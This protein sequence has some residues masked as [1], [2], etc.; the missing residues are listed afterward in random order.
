M[1]AQETTVDVRLTHDLAK[2][3]GISDSSLRRWCRILEFQGYQFVLGED[4]ARVF[5]ERDMAALQRFQILV[6]H[7]RMNLED[8]AKEVMDAEAGR[9]EDEPAAFEAQLTALQPAG[10][11]PV[12]QADLIAHLK[13]TI[14]T[15]VRMGLLPE[16]LT[17]KQ[18][19]NEMDFELQELKVR[20]KKMQQQFAEQQQEL[21][22]LKG[23]IENRVEQRDKELM[24]AL[25]EIQQTKTQIAASR[26]RRWWKF[27]TWSE[28]QRG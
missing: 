6:K 14:E 12:P 9:P 23:Y 16:L 20:S 26:D 4:G 3:L 10:E 1:F 27:W 11:V 28:P 25:R 7:K 22:T 18:T 17:L 24:Y 2:Q 13:T 21:F 19:I 8:A 15:E 5:R